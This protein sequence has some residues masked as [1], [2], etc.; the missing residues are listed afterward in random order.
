MGDEYCRIDII[1]SLT[2]IGEFNKRYLVIFYKEFLIYKNTASVMPA[3]L[4]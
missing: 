3:V 2:Y 1:Y 4:G